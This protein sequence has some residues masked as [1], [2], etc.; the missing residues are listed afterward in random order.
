MEE[1]NEAK[2]IKLNIDV[3]GVIRAMNHEMLY[4]KVL[5]EMMDRWYY[6]R[7][8][9]WMYYDISSKKAFTERYIV[10]DDY[11]LMRSYR[12]PRHYTL[13]LYRKPLS[14]KHG[15]VY[16]ALYDLV[17][18]DHSLPEPLRNFLSKVFTSR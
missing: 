14:F 6:N 13:E 7:H 9:G 3:L 12:G 5:E 15:L 16:G 8:N 18:P 17:L 2:R 1:H 4:S 10:T 11:H